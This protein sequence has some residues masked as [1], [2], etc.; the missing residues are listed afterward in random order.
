MATA[1]MSNKNIHDQKLK[2]YSRKI[3]IKKIIRTVICVLL[4][5]LSL[6]PFYIMIINATRS[7]DAIKTGIALI[8]SDFFIN[9]WNSLMAKSAG[10]QTTL[11]GA[12]LNSALITVPVTILSIYFSTMTAY[13]IHTYNFRGRRF[14]WSFILAVMMV[15]S[16]VT[17]IG[18]MDFILKIGLYDSFFAI[19]IPA[20]A[21]PT[22][23]FFMRQYMQGAF[24]V[25]I[26]E[27]ARIDG[28]GEFRTFNTIALP[29][30]RPALATQAIFGFIASWNNLFTPSM[31]LTSPTKVTL[32]MFVQQLRSEQ[33][34]TDYGMV[35]MGLFITIIPLFVV[36]F[37]LSRYIV[38][39]VALG[40]VKE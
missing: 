9:N 17:I 24:S 20:I 33:F 21:A 8:P 25:E 11:W 31:V 4:A 3:L 32:P 14:A 27:A 7:S 30:M 23:V 6:F 26:V 13:G 10:L 5:I 40:G 37:L 34:R 36:Y 16:Q 29:L 38:A 18:F 12:I 19:I 22:T 39:G 35:Y 1:V 15:P 28:A 2:S